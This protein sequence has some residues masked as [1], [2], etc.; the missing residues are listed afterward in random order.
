MLPKTLRLRQKKDIQTLFAKGKSVF[1][2]YFIIRFRKNQLPTTR[3]TVI[4]GKKVSKKAVVRNRLKRQ[5]RALFQE[6]LPSVQQGFDIALIVQAKAV[7][8]DFAVLKN[9]YEQ[10]IHKTP[11][12]PA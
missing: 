3:F 12:Y 4:V 5:L 10:T 7:G 11:L 2:L 8:V 6:S 9:A 1:H